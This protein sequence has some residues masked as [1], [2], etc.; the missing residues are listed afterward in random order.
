M[1]R[2]GLLGSVLLLLFWLL[3]T[4]SYAAE[5]DSLSL[6]IGQILMIGFRGLSIAEA[7][8]GRAHV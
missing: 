4:P 5:P 2:G 6:K 3:T 7:Q 1:K 8:I